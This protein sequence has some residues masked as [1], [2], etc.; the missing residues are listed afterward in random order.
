MNSD[1]FIYTFVRLQFFKYVACI[2]VNYFGRYLFNC[3]ARVW[4]NYFA[5]FWF[6]F[7]A[8][9]YNLICLIFS[10]RGL[11]I[12]MTISL[13]LILFLLWGYTITIN[14]NVHNII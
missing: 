11:T 8:H 14:D 1:F 7:F 3:L 12:F 10:E 2:W 13:S 9:N 6:N 4:F 5:C